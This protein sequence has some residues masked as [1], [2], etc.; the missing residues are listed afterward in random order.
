[1]PRILVASDADWIKNEIEGALL[2]P[3]TEVATVDRGR[4]V[5]PA[6]REQAP[7]VVILDLQIGN[8]GAAAVCRDLRNEE[9]AGRMPRRTPVVFLLDRRPDAFLA[10]RADADAWLEKPISP[11]ALQRTLDALL[12]G[13]TWSPET[14]APSQPAEEAPLL[15][16]GSAA[17]GVTGDSEAIRA[18]SPTT[19]D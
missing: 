16:E 17:E 13:E 3:G 10:R 8:M 2:S 1:M 9:E 7:D 18:G 4:D 11:R 5:V 15:T 19:G 12:A 14:V 6:M